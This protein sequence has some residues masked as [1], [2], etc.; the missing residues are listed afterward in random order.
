MKKAQ[1][2][3]TMTLGDTDLDIHG[4]PDQIEEI[5]IHNTDIEMF[6]LIHTLNWDGFKA[7]FYEAIYA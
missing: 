6:E 5:Y 7:K 3:V 2:M 1:F 4:S